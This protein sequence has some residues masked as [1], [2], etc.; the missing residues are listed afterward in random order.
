MPKLGPIRRKELIKYLK[1]L[2]FEGPFSGGNH[3]FLQR[4]GLKVWVP[5]PHHGEGIGRNFLRR[6]LRQA[7]ISESEWE[8]L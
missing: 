8:K 4:E 6:I 5:N 7:E 2:G 1:L 3:E